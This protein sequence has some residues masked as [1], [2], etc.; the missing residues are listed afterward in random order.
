MAG[1]SLAKHLNTDAPMTVY[2]YFFFFLS[3]AIQ[4]AWAIANLFISYTSYDIDPSTPGSAIAGSYIIV[5]LMMIPFITSAFSAAAKWYDD[6]GK[7]T[8]FLFI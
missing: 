3:Y 7:F 1:F 5:Y 2:H 6:K 4:Y 8:L